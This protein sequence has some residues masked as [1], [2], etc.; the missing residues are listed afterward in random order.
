MIWNYLVEGGSWRIRHKRVKNRTMT[1][2]VASLFLPFQPQFE[3]LDQEQTAELVD[4]KLVK[5]SEEVVERPEELYSKGM[6]QIPGT[7]S[8]PSLD[9]QGG[10]LSSE[11][12]LENLTANA[13]TAGTPANPALGVHTH[14]SAEDFFISNTALDREDTAYSKEFNGDEGSSLDVTA[15]LLDNVNKSLLLHS[16]LNSSQN[17]AGSNAV[18]GTPAS[19]PT[20][21]NTTVITPKSRAVPDNVQGVVNFDNYKKQPNA[22]QFPSMKRVGSGS[23]GSSH[24]KYSQNSIDLAFDGDGVVVEDDEKHSSD[25][26]SDYET[27]RKVH[28]NVPGFGGYSS[29]SKR[30]ESSLDIFS[31]VPWKI[32]PSRKGNGALKNAINTA[33]LEKDITTP[34]KW[35]GTMSIP[36]DEIPRETTGKIVAELDE[37]Y[38]SSAVIVDDVTFKGAYKN[39]CKQIL[40]PTLHYQIPDNPNSKAF[41]DHSWN[42]FQRLNQY[43]ADKITEVYKDGDI[44]WVHDYHLMLVPEMIRQKIPTAKIGF[45]LHVSFP[46]SEVFRCFAQR[47]AM[48]E[49]I[50]GSNFVGFQTTEYARHFLTTAN[51]LLTADITGDELRYKGKVIT[52]KSFPVGIDSFDLTNQLP[53]ESVTKWRQLIRERWAGK[54]LIV[55]RDQF[56]KIRGLDKKLLAYERFLRE[57]PEYIEKVVLIQ[58]CIGKSQD[59]EL[60]RKIMKVVDRINSLSISI[61]VSQPVV[62]LHQ[63]LEFSQYLAL[64][65]ESD[66]FLIN[67]LREGMNLTS[68]EFIVCSREKNSPLLISEFTGSA[69]LLKG[70][71]LL[72]NPWDTK[73]LAKTIK[74]G[75]EMPMDEKKRRWK[76]MMK[77][78]IN[79]DSTN[80]MISNLQHIE[81]CWEFSKESSTLFNLSIDDVVSD[82]SQS[83]NKLFILKLSEPPNPRMLAI[84]RELSAKNIVYIM[85]SFSKT[86][87]ENLYG[88]VGNLGLI[89]ESGAYVR[90]NGMW[91]SIVDRVDWLEEVTKILDTK[92]ERLPGSYYKLADSMVRFHTE[93]AEDQE[94]V[95]GVIGEA[96][97]HINTLFADRGIHAYVH[98]N[99]LFVQQ[100][101]LSLE[102]T[103]FILKFHNHGRVYNTVKSSPVKPNHEMDTMFSS[104]SARSIDF[105]FAAGSTSPIIE[106][107][108]RLV[109]DAITDGNL[110]HGHTVVYGDA[111]STYAREHTSGWN[112]LFNIFQDLSKH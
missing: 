83:T 78:L 98:K 26:E 111:P 2:I 6:R 41:E 52:V 24:L 49:G 64:S 33:I 61:S 73:H 59:S 72:I 4:S 15:N 35:V 19:H 56:D 82:Y 18:E 25:N 13:T 12:F 36:T 43:F 7:G 65:S 21:P 74:E 81:N 112:E 14:A 30:L 79:N 102:A 44:V 32:V 85:N 8:A 55:C 17:C 95:A 104:S 54:K 40:W 37:K 5:V 90:L 58:I 101:E 68:Q 20:N 103:K 91:Y 23:H 110:K 89:A 99:I 29:G 11:Q 51:L 22:S 34:V 66:L 94:R 31:R 77:S 46:S 71:A 10:P 27:D 53:S 86:T 93:N 63:D 48:L 45:F 47:E 108:F 76:R 50:L 105:I 39:F 75:L 106:P 80:W 3:V 87:L 16:V 67:T 70:G 9:S 57:N 92:I 84:L 42:Y 1:I 38:Q 69:D 109:K 60:E 96:M 62:F 97:T 100:K 88:R 107:I 28:Y